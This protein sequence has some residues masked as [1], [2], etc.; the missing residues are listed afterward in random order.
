MTKNTY[1]QKIADDFSEIKRTLYRHVS[2]NSSGNLTRSQG[3]LLFL[4]EK[5]HVL[6]FKQIAQL[7]AVSSGAVTQLVDSLVKYGLIKRRQ[8][9][10]DRR[11]VHILLT[12]KGLS[13][14]EAIRELYMNGFREMFGNL[15]EPELRTLAGI[16]NKL[17]QN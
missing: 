15:T 17:V 9:E 12:D 4:I 14:A 13:R 7:L 10:Q 2:D 5:H 8:D 6:H 11:I 1:I 16:L 3:E